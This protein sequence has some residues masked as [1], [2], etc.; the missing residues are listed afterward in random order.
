VFG[1]F[2]AQGVVVWNSHAFNLTAESTAN[3]QWWNIYFAGTNHRKYPARGIFDDT[4]I[5]VQNVPPFEEREYCRTITMGIGT[6]LYYL[7]S[8]THLRGR[9]FRVWGPGIATSCRSTQEN[10]GACTPDTGPPILVTTE[11]NDPAQVHFDPPLVLDDP[12]PAQ[13]RFKF[14]SIYD[15][16]GTE[17]ALVKRNSTSP[18]PPQFGTLAPGGPCYVAGGLFPR[19]LGVACLDGPRR[20]LACAGDDRQCDSAPGAGDGKCDACPL[21]GGVTTEDEMFILLGGY[22][23]VPG[24]PCEAGSTL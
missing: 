21:R 19:D 18:I 5:F 20:G 10:P 14:C 4:D 3:Q 6:R 7:S 2:P 17:A 16:G 24:T 9:L 22:Y 11:Y 1:I 15:N 12:D 13:R 8:H 23:C